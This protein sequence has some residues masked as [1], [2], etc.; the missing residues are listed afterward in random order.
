MWAARILIWCLKALTPSSL[1]T[2]ICCSFTNLLFSAFFVCVC[3]YD[4]LDH[5]CGGNCSAQKEQ[6]IWDFFI[7]LQLIVHIQQP[8]LA[9]NKHQQESVTWDRCAEI[10]EKNDYHG[11]MLLSRD[12]LWS[13]D[14]SLGNSKR[15]W[16]EEV[17]FLL[18][19]H[20]F[21]P[22]CCVSWKLILLQCLFFYIFIFVGRKMMLFLGKLLIR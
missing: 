19:A 2:Y 12:L 8:T 22:F 18:I 20:F 21:L 17:D 15:L 7:F 9:K 3:F 10:L 11:E 13:F 16:R 4:Q 5:C 6:R 1:F 14:F